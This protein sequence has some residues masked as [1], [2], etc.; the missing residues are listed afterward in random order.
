MKRQYRDWRDYLVRSI[1]EYMPRDV[2]Y[3]LLHSQ[4]LVGLF[5]CIFVKSASSHRVSKLDASEV[6]RGMGGLAGNKVHFSLQVN[7]LLID[8]GSNHHPIHV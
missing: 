3:E 7:T 6:K 2:G 8:L 5:S 4:I 1:R